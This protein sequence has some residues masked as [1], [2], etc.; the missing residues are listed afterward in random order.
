MGLALILSY[1]HTV[2]IKRADS[3]TTNSD[4]GTAGLV[5]AEGWT[6]YTWEEYQNRLGSARW[7]LKVEKGEEIP[8]VDGVDDDGIDPTTG[9]YVDD[10]VYYL[11]EVEESG[12]M[13]LVSI[14][15]FIF[16]V[17][18]GPHFYRPGEGGYEKF[19]RQ[20]ITRALALASLE[21]QELNKGL[22]N[23]DEPALEEAK[24]AFLKTYLQ[25]Y[26][27]LGR[28]KDPPWINFSS[29]N[30]SNGSFT[31]FTKDSKEKEAFFN[32]APAFQYD[33]SIH[34]G[35][36]SAGNRTRRHGREGKCPMRKVGETVMAGYKMIRER[37]PQLMR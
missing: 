32:A 10:V 25:K 30:D 19:N 35:V 33:P 8:I 22:E 29:D 31:N 4:G 1:L 3:S 18:D 17:T 24:D 6:L 11:N 23:L 26:P 34:N 12:E 27:L 20:E 37:I 21:A 9:R 28:L 5:D 16:N 14:Y 2:R 36:I 15:G 13:L 7:K